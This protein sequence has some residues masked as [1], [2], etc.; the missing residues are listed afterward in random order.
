M[1]RRNVVWLIGII[2]AASLIAG[3]SSWAAEPTRPPP[4]RL[5]ADGSKASSGDNTQDLEATLRRLDLQIGRVE[6]EAVRTRS[7]KNSGH[8]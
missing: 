6:P 7:A 5:T 2:G 1:N 4:A 3:W 8:Q